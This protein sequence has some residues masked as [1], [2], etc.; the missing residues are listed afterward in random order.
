MKDCKAST[1]K[2]GCENTISELIIQV[3]IQQTLKLV[4][5]PN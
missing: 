5:S 3:E 1:F 4:Y 2:D